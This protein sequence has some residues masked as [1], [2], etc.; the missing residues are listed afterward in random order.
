MKIAVIGATGKAGSFIVKEAVNRGHEV[1]AIVRA[2]KKMK[3]PNVQILRKS[4]FS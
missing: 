3:E 4:Y 2:K 1:L